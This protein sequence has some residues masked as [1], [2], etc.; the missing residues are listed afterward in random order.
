MEILAFG[1]TSVVEED[2][3]FAKKELQ[4]KEN[5]NKLKIKLYAILPES[6]TSCKKC[7][8]RRTTSTTIQ[9]QRSDEPPVTQYVCESPTCGHSWIAS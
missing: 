5:E 8:K 3:F 1:M 4:K 6:L 7:G 2:L 9:K